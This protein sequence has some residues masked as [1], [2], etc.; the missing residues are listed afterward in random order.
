MVTT[1]QISDELKEAL[2][3]RKLSSE[4]TYEDVI[5]YLIENSFTL[6]KETKRAIHKSK[7]DFEKGDILSNEDV[8]KEL[9][10]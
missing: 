7:Q 2:T 1:I 8:K 5:W 9:G 4:E 3:S 10:I 6:N